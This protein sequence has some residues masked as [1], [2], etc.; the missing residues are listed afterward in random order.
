MSVSGI[1]KAGV[2]PK[3]RGTGTV[4]IYVCGREERVS[5]EVKAELQTLVNK[6]RE[7]NVDVQVYHAG[8]VDYDLDVTVV[9][10]SGY[11]ISEVTEKLTTAFKEYIYTLP[12]GGKLYLSSI[13]RY[14]LDTDC[15]ENYE[16]NMLMQN[17]EVSGSQCFR[18]GKINITV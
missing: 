7:L 6:E 9:P 14:F 4:N 10:K 3:V 1:E 8:F 11:S 12:I 2:V 16:F 15:I 13:G 5:D 18:A 17:K